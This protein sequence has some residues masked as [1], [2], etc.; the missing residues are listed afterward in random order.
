LF[1][2]ETV[3]I[4]LNDVNE[5]PVIAQGQAFQVDEHVPALTQVGNV[6]AADPDSGQALTFTIQG[7]NTNNAFAIDAV[8]GEITV[9]GNICFEYCSQY[10]LLVRATDNGSPALFNEETVVILLN[11]VNEAPVI[12]QGQFFQVDEHVPALTQV[13]NV[14]A[15]DPDSG[16]ALTFTIQGGNT[17]NA[18]AIDAA[19]GEITV[20]GNICFE[21]CSQYTLLVRATDNGIPALSGEETVVILLNDV[22]EA[23]VIAQGQA[24][25]VDEHVP[26]LTQVGSVMAADPDS[27]QSLTFTIQGGNTNNAFAIDAVTGEITVAGNIC[28][29][30][31]SQYTLLVRATD[32]GTPALSGEETVVILLNDVN[33]APVIADQSFGVSRT[34][35]AGTL[36]GTVEASDPDFNQTL[37][38][39][40]T[41]GNPDNIFSIDPLSG[42]LS[43]NNSDALM[44][45]ASEVFTLNILAEDNG[46]PVLSAS[47]VASVTVTDSNL[48]PSIGNQLFAID[49]NAASGTLVGQVNA[50]DPDQG[51][52]LSFSITG[53]NIDNAFQ[54]SENGLLSVANAGLMD[55]ET[56]PVF[57]LTVQ[58]TDNGSPALSASAMV[59]VELNDINEAP[60]IAQGQAFQVDEHVPAL[61]Q[62]GN[63]MAA[64]PDSGQA[65]TFTIQGGNTNNAFAI[66]AVTGEITVAGN[67][68]FEYCSQYTLLVRA[69]DN[70]SPALFNEETVVILLNDVNEAPVIAQGQ[71]FQ[72]NE[73]VPALTQ[74][75]NVLAAD[76]DSG[77]A[78]TF[79][80]QGGNTNNA[81]AIDAVTGEITVAGNICFEYCSQYNL[82][83]RATDNGT[84]ALSGEETV[85]ILLNDV[86]EAP[87]ITDQSFGVSRTAPA[88]TL[89]GTAEASD[90]DFN[91][92]LTFAI[93]GG[94]PDNIFSID[95]LSG[96]LFI[97]STN[98]LGIILEEFVYLNVTVTDNGS[99]QQAS[100]AIITIILDAMNNNPVIEDQEFSIEENA[101][102][103]MEVGQIAAF[104]PDADQELTFSIAD[105]NTGE[106]FSLSPEGSLTVLNSGMLNYET[107]PIFQLVVTASD[108]GIPSM[109]AQAVVT[110]RLDNVNEPP[111]LNPQSFF[112]E[113]SLPNGQFVGTVEAFDPESGSNLHFEIISGNTGNAFRL[114]PVNGQLYIRNSAAINFEE[115]PI[116]YLMVRVSDNDNLATEEIITINV[117]D[118]NDPPE[119]YNFSFFADYYSPEGTLIGVVEAID[120][121]QGQVLTYEFMEGNSDNIFSI[122]PYTGEIFINNLTAF[123][124]S[125][126]GQYNLSVK[127][128]DNGS[129]PMS[130]LFFVKI[131]IARPDVEKT[132]VSDNNTTL[133]R[134]DFKAYPNPSTDGRFTLAFES[135]PSQDATI[136]ITDI[137]GIVIFETKPNI[138]L[139]Y[140]LDLSHL[141][142][143]FYIIQVTNGQYRT[144]DKLIIQ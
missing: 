4:L 91:Q 74:V 134:L 138:T 7:G 44:A 61:T 121:D 78:L 42:E 49:E 26:A 58:V 111:V 95:P 137:S 68:C 23:P 21:Y 53:G 67:I 109:S 101:A 75:G 29:E 32:N 127:V 31:C 81:F 39:A 27:G 80:I 144:K 56:Y 107:T 43:V 123:R 1:N 64:D 142:K 71:A 33:E 40:I 73:H 10:N 25:Q 93:T 50:T 90:P 112:I 6:M 113:E 47:A 98:T 30:Y 77:Q 11:D 28:F 36:I 125:N 117:I 84:T 116:F 35:Q 86:N 140:P 100:G 48:P 128:S 51:Q 115:N 41:G 87:V 136:S 60:V 52:V 3:V 110:I 22:N 120:P 45:S 143:G 8:T 2:E 94:N 114:H 108:N 85:V 13:G 82:L 130:S 104:D 79:T 66:D 19:T 102:G 132:I 24:F 76:P 72:V 63:V 59:T 99:P 103:G 83:V 131:A 119:T 106:A 38:F 16:Q 135:M 118:G 96:E 15:A 62:V 12:A 20:A 89:I 55:Y 92:T 46:N 124:A 54:I 88:G 141:N 65:L 69:T 57:N 97:T 14:L 133:K 37:T 139:N 70:G 105:G 5:A 122:H 126:T 34:A 129:P 17:N 18:F 9:A